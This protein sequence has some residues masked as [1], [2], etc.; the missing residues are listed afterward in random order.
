MLSNSML[1]FI[2]IRKVPREVLKS[3]DFA[4]GFQHLSRDLA[5]VNE[6]DPSIEPRSLI[7]ALLI[8]TLLM[9]GHKISNQP[10]SSAIVLHTKN[11]STERLTKI[12]VL[13][14]KDKGASS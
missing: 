14:I 7:I 13:K 5:N 6:F 3:Y 4:L 12:V 8:A 1:L 2:N 11:V 9:I 10:V